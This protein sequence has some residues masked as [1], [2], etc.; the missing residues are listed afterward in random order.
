MHLSQT[1]PSEVLMVPG[2][3]SHIMHMSL[4]LHLGRSVIMSGRMVLDY[5]MYV[6]GATV[7]AEHPK[8]FIPGLFRIP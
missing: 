5:K 2:S 6:L 7:S 3:E 1:M 8:D 4:G